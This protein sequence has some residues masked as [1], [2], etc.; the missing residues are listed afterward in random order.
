[1]FHLLT[2]SSSRRT[3]VYHS[4]MIGGQRRCSDRTYEPGM[5]GP[6]FYVFR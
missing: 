6:C 5:D 3:A 4:Y 2:A 1:V